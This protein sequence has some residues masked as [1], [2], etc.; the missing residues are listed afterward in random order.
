MDRRTE[1]LSTLTELLSG[2]APT[3]SVY[4]NRGELKTTQR[5][6]FVLFNADELP[7][8]SPLADRRGIS[9]PGLLGF[10]T[11]QPEL[12]YLHSD[13]LPTVD[14]GGVIEAMRVTLI[15]LVLNSVALREI[16][17]ANGEIRYLGAVTDLA[18]GRM[19]TGQ[20]QVKFL[21]KYPLKL[22]DL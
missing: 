17:G 15:K 21:F 7:D 8:L 14:V 13:N 2:I 18:D 19:M 6:A 3:V 1:I 9:P 16:V 11:T 5:P 12:F 10:M 4:R 20:L 22:S